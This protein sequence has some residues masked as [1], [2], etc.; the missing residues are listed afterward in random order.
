MNDI[1]KL[2]MTWQG[3]C[4]YYGRLKSDVMF[5]DKVNIVHYRI[6]GR[7]RLTLIINMQFEGD[8]A[9]STKLKVVRWAFL[10]TSLV[11]FPPMPL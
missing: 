8:I 2:E 10:Q 3:W 4:F 7:Q 5:Q 1:G 9:W 11:H 6:I